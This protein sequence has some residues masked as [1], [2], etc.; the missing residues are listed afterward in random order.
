MA[1]ESKRTLKEILREAKEAEN[2][3]NIEDA[4][5]LYQ[6][7]IST[8]ELNEHAYNR[9]MMLFRRQKEYKKELRI[10][11]AGIKVFEEFYESK[12]PNK[13]KTI[14]AISNKLNKSFGLADKK[15][16]RIYSPEPIAKWKKRKLIVEKRIK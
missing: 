16:N 14:T 8:D 7:A 15:G 2:T 13:S 9:L 1:V 6:E 10:I 11:K 3:E 4:I 5:R 12:I